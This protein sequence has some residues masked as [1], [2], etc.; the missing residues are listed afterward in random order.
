MQDHPLPPIWDA[1]SRALILGS[2]PSVR[3]RAQGFYYAHPQNRFWRVL[4]SVYDE[5]LPEG[6]P[7][8]EA[9]LHRHGLALWDV[10]GRCEIAGSS[11]AT[12]RRAQPNDL[13][14]LLS[15]AKLEAVFLN[16]QTAARLYARWQSQIPLPARTLPSTSPANASW[17]LPRLVEAWQALALTP[18]TGGFFR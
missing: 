8:K 17:T 7:E 13:T 16:G 1:E 14:P 2:F 5:P 3:S 11:D 4:S 12:I 9:F 18:S 6:I 15:G 10:V